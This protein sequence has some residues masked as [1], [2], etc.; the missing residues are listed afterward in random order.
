MTTI[1]KKQKC[2]MR[3]RDR[4]KFLKLTEQN[5]KKS[6]LIHPIE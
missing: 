5:E 6:I 3:E 1:I 4:E 2:Q